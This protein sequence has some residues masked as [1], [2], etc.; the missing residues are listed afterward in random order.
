ML[1]RLLV[2]G[3]LLCVPVACLAVQLEDGILC[4]RGHIVDESGAN[5]TGVAVSL[6]RENDS[7]QNSP[8][9]DA[10]GNF[11][12]CGLAAV[13]YRMDVRKSGYEDAV[14]YA[15]PAADNEPAVQIT[16]TREK[17]TA[18]AQNV[19]TEVGSIEGFLPR[20]DAHPS[21]QN[22]DQDHSA[23]LSI[24]DV[25]DPL[26]TQKQRMH[27]QAEATWGLDWH[28]EPNATLPN[29]KMPDPIPVSYKGVSV[30]GEAGKST[31]FAAYEK[32]AVD[33]HSMLQKMAIEELRA[34]KVP[35]P[36]D[37]NALS[38]EAF[39]ARV[40]RQFNDHDSAYARFRHDELSIRRTRLNQEDAQSTSSKGLKIANQQIDVA[41]TVAITPTISN[42]TRVSVV[43]NDAQLPSGAAAQR[44]QSGL[45]TIRR[46]RV[47]EAA[48]N[49]YRQTSGQNL[50][51]GADFMAN[52]M[53]L[54]F[55]E[56]GLGRVSA[57]NSSLSQSDHA[58]EL[59]IVSQHKLRPNLEATTGI[60]YD[61]QS[62]RGFKGD[63]N[64]LAPQ[65]GLA[66]AVTPKT[67]I[68]GG[69]S[70]Y[71]DQ[72]PLPALAG[73]SD[74]DAAA[75]LQ[76]SGRF[77]NRNGLSA[78]E[79]GDFVL[80]APTIQNS[81]AEAANLQVDQQLGAKT[82]LS[83]QT[84]YVHGVQLALPV[85]KAASVCASTGACNAGNTF[86]GQEL[87]SGAVSSYAGTT[88]ALT[89][90][91]VRWGSYKVSY[92]LA[93]SFGTGSDLNTSQIADF[94]RRA[95]VTGNLHT[96][97]T[98]GSSFWQQLSHGIVLTETMD[99]TTKSEFAGFQFFNIDAR[100]TKTLAWG[101]NFRLD[102]LAQTMNMFQR[103]SASYARSVA[104]LGPGASAV[105]AA[106]RRVASMQLPQGNQMG[107]R[108]IF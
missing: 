28:T 9:S 62:M 20:T 84:E 51:M 2:T 108:L 33:P 61:L 43:M 81:Y 59:Y 34:G 71:Y 83:A 55:V 60:R 87:G 53:N 14:A 31:Y 52:Q 58:A 104:Q 68:R 91:P 22:S 57:G 93:Q 4:L 97:M 47:F 6:T 21:P 16:L 18:V 54:A 74:P 19:Q 72:I 106:Y 46:N 102:A 63:A 70:V 11:V 103:T 95:S 90:Q 40:D 39:L 98:P 94:M 23:P 89:Q 79:L 78:G 101:K 64:N 44:V 32:F 24:K 49:V 66:W 73:S 82:T 69:V 105:F 92:T 25:S 36:H 26:F 1:H 48:S 56:S 65:L 77:V 50:R 35:F 29:A 76:S 38:A 88:I 85:L 67:V 42:E 45:P 37:A 96:S 80:L 75:N 5:A 107:L 100:L 7:R 10:N 8:I 41:N 86:S 12:A 99:Y 13:E 27:G 30:G 3:G 17:A 15:T